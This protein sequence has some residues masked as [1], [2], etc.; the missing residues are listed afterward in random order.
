M[1][2][3]VDLPAPFS[4]RS[5]CTSP[6]ATSRSTWSLASTPGKRLVIPRSSRTGGSSTTGDSVTRKAGLAARLPSRRSTGLL[7]GR[8]DLDLPG[9][10]L[11]LECLDPRLV[12]SR[13]LRADLA[14]RDAAV[15]QV[16]DEVVTRRERAVLD[17]MDE[18]EHAEIDAL[19]RARQDVRPEVRL[20][21]VDTVAPDTR[22]LGGRESAEAAGAGDREHD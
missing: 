6:A 21:D 11:G 5:A 3:S 19:D 16:E 9:D 1:F 4:P 18:A 22:L 10:D 8:R 2:I 7:E 12:G 13:H 20:V 14:D 15:L 17:R